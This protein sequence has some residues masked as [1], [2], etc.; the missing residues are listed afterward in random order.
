MSLLLRNVFFFS[1]I[2]Y[3]TVS[4]VLRNALTRNVTEPTERGGERIERRQTN[5][6][7]CLPRSK[8]TQSISGFRFAR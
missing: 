8:Y 1:L 2:L 3:I 6:T 7:R 4:F 5:L